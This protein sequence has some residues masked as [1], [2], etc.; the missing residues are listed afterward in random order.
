M[1]NKQL[2]FPNLNGLRFIAAALV[3]IHH[4]EQAKFKAGFDGW[5]LTSH[6]I[7]IIGKLGVVLFFVLSGF[8]ITYL[9]LHEE[10]M[11]GEISIKKFYLRRIFRI[12]PLY[13]LIL[14][15]AFFIL[16][17]INAYEIFNTHHFNSNDTPKI[18]LYIFFLGNLVMISVGTVPFASHLWSIGT[19]E[20]FYIIWP[21]LF[22]KIKKN[23]IVIFILLIIA[24]FII[25]SLLKLFPEN[26]AWHQ[27]SRFFDYFNIDCM[28]I[29]S[30]FAFLDYQKH[31]LV[32]YLKINAL[33]YAVLLLT[34]VMLGFGVFIPFVQYQVYSVLF[35]III[36][37][38][39]T[40]HKSG[41]NIENKAM[42]YLGDIS[43]GL[44]MYHP[45]A[46]AS[47]LLILSTTGNF[48]NLLLYPLVFAITIA[49]ASISY[50]YFE[51]YFLKIK[52]RFS[53]V[54]VNK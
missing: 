2:Y 53:I 33:F 8:L 31:V 40:N 14:S 39:A 30:I 21:V 37:N 27:L 44:Y 19:E 52:N 41:I 46:I 38:L 7:G 28:L 45:I 43:Y 1:S 17:E 22:D 12:W 42:K 10:A 9:L 11:K 15:L 4:I 35:G 36:L 6:F 18:L 20:Q 50:K 51:S 47:A 34:I 25:Q 5:W 54:T 23:R 3:I 24:L 49:V 16:P 48:S 32:S 29:G 13:F 26:S